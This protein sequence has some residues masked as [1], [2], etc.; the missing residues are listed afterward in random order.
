MM[1]ADAV[2]NAAAITTIVSA[3]ISLALAVT[4]WI[5]INKP[6]KREV[7]FTGTPVDKKDFDAAMKERKEELV[8]AHERID[9]WER[10]L[11][12]L[13]N[14]VSRL[15]AQCESLNQATCQ[16]ASDVRRLADKK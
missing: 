9:E 5:T 11:M 14:S 8:R 16:L 1:I 12:P 4:V 7:F 15:G 13:A 2:N 3:A 6:Q 10:Q